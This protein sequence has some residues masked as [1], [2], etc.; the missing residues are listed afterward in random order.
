MCGVR[1][2]VPRDGLR[3]VPSARRQGFLSHRLAR[4]SIAALR[5]S[6]EVVRTLGTPPEVSPSPQGSDHDVV[7][8]EVQRPFRLLEINAAYFRDYVDRPSSQFAVW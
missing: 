5:L 4:A 6:R 3:S 1:R 7:L 2:F 8:S